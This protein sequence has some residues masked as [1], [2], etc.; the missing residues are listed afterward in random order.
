MKSRKFIASIALGLLISPAFAEVKNTTTSESNFTA[1]QIS[2]L[3]KKYDSSIQIASLS[4][5]EMQDTEGAFNPWG[6]ALGAAGGGIGYGINNYI[7]G[8]PWSWYS[9]GTSVG[10]GAF[11]GSGAGA[12]AA[13]WQFNGAIGTGIANGIAG[14]YNW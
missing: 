12:A 3:F 1:V 4:K 10:G 8:Q 5:Q 9:F 14:F 13:I 2:E 7:S 6:A 11:A